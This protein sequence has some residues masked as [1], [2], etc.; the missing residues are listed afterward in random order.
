MR[1]RRK[2]L[3][4]VA[5]LA[6]PVTSFTVFGTPSIFAGAAAPTFPVACKVTADLTFTPPLTE[7]GTH[8]TN[9]SAV[10]TITLSSGKLTGCLSG[11]SSGA[12]SKGVL[13]T[14]SAAMD[15]PA[16]SLGRIGGVK[17]YATGYCPA[18]KPTDTTTLKALRGLALKVTWTGG[19]AGFSDF[20][21]SSA[22]AIA[23]NANRELGWV[24]QGK[25]GVGTYAEKSVNQMTL[26]FDATSSA[27][28]DAGCSSAQVVSSGSWDQSNSVAMI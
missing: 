15:V 27:A 2:V 14:V 9:R 13:T 1:G 7:G 25:E 20:T 26:Y 8:T 22:T 28:M 3:W 5:V 6:V 18:F 10:T 4:A 21:V 16:T 19:E 12:P 11:A 23:S 24:L 17:T